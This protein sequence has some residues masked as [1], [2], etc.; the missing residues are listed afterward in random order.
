MASA[1]RLACF[2]AV[3]RTSPLTR[4]GISIALVALLAGGVGV[5]ATRTAQQQ[6]SLSLWG[7]DEYPHRAIGTHVELYA[8]GHEIAEEDLPDATDASN[9]ET[10]RLARGEYTLLAFQMSDDVVSGRGVP[11]T[12]HLNHDLM[13]VPDR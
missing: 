5:A 12:V 2:V 10:Y 13:I 6:F 4:A 11:T 8:Q 9:V 7:H 3:R 1:W